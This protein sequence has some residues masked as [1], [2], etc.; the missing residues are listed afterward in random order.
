MKNRFLFLPMLVLVITLLVSCDIAP[1]N[2]E[3]QESL[4]GEDYITSSTTVLM[5]EPIPTS[6][7]VQPSTP[8]PSEEKETEPTG[9]ITG[10]LYYMDI[11]VALLFEYPFR[12]IDILGEPSDGRDEFYFFH[13]GLVVEAR[14]GDWCYILRRFELVTQIHG[15]DLSLFNIDGI[16]LEKT[17]DELIE[18]FGTPSD[19]PPSFAHREYRLL[20]YYILL[21]ELEYRLDF[22][23]DYPDSV[24]RLF[25]LRRIGS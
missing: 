2:Q 10:T 14:G 12:D 23:F 25:S 7:S 13:D 3:I 24:S 18:I 6:V 8:V 15:D 22:W 21:R 4:S 16:S 1:A 9:V 17:R 19:P 11:E 5:P 20:R